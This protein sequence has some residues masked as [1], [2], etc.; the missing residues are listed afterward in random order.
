M[1]VEREVFTYMPCVVS[2]AAN[3]LHPSIEKDEPKHE[4]DVGHKDEVV[5]PAA[6][7]ECNRKGC[8]QQGETSPRHE[9]CTPPL[10]VD[11]TDVSIDTHGEVLSRPIQANRAIARSQDSATG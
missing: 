8:D 11:I 6:H 4:Q 2:P 10:C 7:K 5:V 1:M 3:L 9:L